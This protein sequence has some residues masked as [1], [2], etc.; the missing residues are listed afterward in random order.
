MNLI[1]KIG[2]VIVFIIIILNTVFCQ[3]KHNNRNFALK[4]E[5]FSKLKIDSIVELN[6]DCFYPKLFGCNIIH[7]KYDKFVKKTKAYKLFV[8]D[9]EEYGVFIQEY[10]FNSNIIKEISPRVIE[11]ANYRRKLKRINFGEV[12]MEPY[13]FQF[14]YAIDI[15]N[16]LYLISD[17]NYN[18]KYKG[19]EDSVDG[20]INRNKE[21]LLDDV[22]QILKKRK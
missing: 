18:Y 13:E 5:V 3:K 1:R 14:Y 15:G 20:I 7:Q 10:T 19:G 22:Y 11:Y 9:K 6:I 2:K 16:R 8:K 12:C 21:I 4:K 17:I